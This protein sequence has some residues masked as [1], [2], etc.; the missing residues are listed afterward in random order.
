MSYSYSTSAPYSQPV[1]NI[2]ASQQGVQ[3]QPVTTVEEMQIP[4]QR[5]GASS[6]GVGITT[7]IVGAA[8][9]AIISLRKNPLINKAGEVSSEYAVK[10]YEKILEKSKDAEK[11][12][13]EQTQELL[14]KIEG[15]KSADE[16]KTLLKQYPEAVDSL[17]KD[18]KKT[19]EK[20][21]KHVNRWNLGRNKKVI[22]QRLEAAN[23]LRY[24]DVKNQIQACWDSN[25]K[26]F[27]KGEGV[28]DTVYEAIKNVKNS[29]KAKAAGK[30]ALVVGGISAVCGFVLHKILSLRARMSAPQNY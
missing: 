15:V 1:S 5:Q 29:T 13:Y 10:T 7:G 11:V 30:K 18:L 12:V 23:N 26:K 4:Q 20:F 25:A 27:V 22:R 9:G 17:S 2:P 24:Q 8:T 16:L 19:P 21:I 6:L 14:K 3:Y 28:S